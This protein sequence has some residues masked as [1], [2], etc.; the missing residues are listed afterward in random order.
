MVIHEVLSTEKVPFTYRV[1]GI[2]ARSLAYL[3]DLPFILLLGFVGVLFTL[4]LA[5][6]GRP[7]LFGAVVQLLFFALT[8]AYF[9][10]FEWL[11]RGQTPGKRLMG[12]RVIQWRG[13]AIGFGQA[14]VRN[15]LRIVDAL[16]LVYG[17]GFAVAGCNRESRRLGDLA[18]DTLVVYVERR[19]RL[20]RT[21]QDAAADPEGQGDRSRVSLVRQRLGQLS[22][23][24]KQTLLDLSLRREQLGVQQRAQLV[25]AVAL[26]LEERLELAPE[27]FESDEKFTLRLA[28][29]LGEQ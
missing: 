8:W 3:I 7:G 9:L 17:V 18:A 19:G 4:P 28:A 20:V 5:A 14:A 27:E 26:Y 23:E 13:T 15:L 12:L 21:L 29:L 22:R 6:A 11:W 2:G 16:P 10:L 24:Q 25:R 1:A